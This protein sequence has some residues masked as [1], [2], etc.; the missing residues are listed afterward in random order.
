MFEE[1]FIASKLRKFSLVDI[2]LVS[3]VYFLVGLLI[4]TNYYPLLHISWIFYFVLICITS[5]PIIL[6]LCTVDGLLLNR[7][8]HYVKTNNQ[9]YQTLLFLTM[10]FLG[11]MAVTLIASL[12]I[13]P[14]YIY[15]I[16]IIILLLSQ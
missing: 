7:I 8:H 5:I 10:F 3:L 15:I 9:A 11:C 13:V 2:C 6:H 4:S 1:E 16:L 12:C 14:S